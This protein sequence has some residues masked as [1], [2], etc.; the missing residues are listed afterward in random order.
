MTAGTGLSDWN[1]SGSLKRELAL[2]RKIGSS[3]NSV[4][5]VSYDRGKD[6]YQLPDIAPIKALP[7][8]WHSRRV[9]TTAE[10]TA[11]YFRQ[12]S[13]TNLIKTNQVRGA[14]IALN[15]SRI[16]GKKLIARC[17]FL[18]SY[19]TERLSESRDR[20]NDA[21]N[22][23]REVFTRAD[24]VVVTTEFQKEY[25]IN[26]Y[27]LDKGMIN[28]IPNYVDTNHFKPFENIEKKYDLVF[29]GRSAPQKNLGI[30]IE[31][32]S[33]L[34]QR[35]ID[36]SLLM[37][38]S[39]GADEMLRGEL[40][41]TGQMVHFTGNLSSEQLPGALNSARAF[42]LPSHFEGHPKALLEAMS[43]GLPCICNDV[44]GIAEE[45]IQG[46]NGILFDRNAE[47]LALSIEKILSDSNLSQSIAESAREHIL[48]SYNLEKV[49]K[50]ELN[51]YSKLIQN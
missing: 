41:K 6:F 7:V 38:G 43:C 50:I 40:E 17:G 28:V 35:K 25:I 42:V 48:H 27:P 36:V 45:I 23:E 3:I 24:A 4:D 39:C 30:L 8:K 47:S 12:L 49:S 5:I 19:F 18:H 34:R 2:Y 29:V 44:E 22:L 14:K 21:V 15:I 37:V 13:R 33:I 26:K 11:R 9:Y 31:A 46:K 32:M 20:I 1:K 51:L 16:F 10:I